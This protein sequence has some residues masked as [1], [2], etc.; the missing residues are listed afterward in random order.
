MRVGGLLALLLLALLA[1]STGAAARDS[2]YPGRNG[3]ILYIRDLGGNEPKGG[4]IFVTA[5]DRSGLGDLAPPGSPMSGRLRS[6]HGRRIAFPRLGPL[7]T[8]RC[9]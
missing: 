8:R 5:P 1:G 9:T 3:V 7:G 4:H 2:A 6:P